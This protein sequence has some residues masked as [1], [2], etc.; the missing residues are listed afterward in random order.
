MAIL[1][2]TATQHASDIFRADDS[3]TFAAITLHVYV[4]L[5]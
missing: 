5:F 4:V 1:I 3:L 2:L